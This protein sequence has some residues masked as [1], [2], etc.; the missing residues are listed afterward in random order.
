MDAWLR[1]CLSANSLSAE[2]DQL[3]AF[4][5][6]L[7]AACREQLATLPVTRFGPVNATKRTS[8]AMRAEVTVTATGYRL[9]LFAPATVLTLICGRKPGKFPNLLAIEQWIEA[10]GIVPRP[11]QNGKSISTKSLAY[12]I[13]RKIANSG[14]TVFV[15]G[16]PSK[17]FADILSA[18]KVGAAIKARLLPLLVLQIRTEIHQA[19]TV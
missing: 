17:L 8:D 5:A 14:N 18:P 16:P 6:E 1:E 3:T 11:D 4:G 13:G 15:Q 9:Q 19:L 7:L 12:L 2:L 10:R